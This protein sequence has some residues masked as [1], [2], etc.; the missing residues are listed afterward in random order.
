MADYVDPDIAPEHDAAL[1]RTELGQGEQNISWSQEH[2]VVNLGG[3]TTHF[4]VGCRAGSQ[5]YYLTWLQR[6]MI[7]AE[8]LA[9][10]RVELS[11][12]CRANLGICRLP[13]L[14]K[15]VFWPLCSWSLRSS[16]GPTPWK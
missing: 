15:L 13:P 16:L 1:S 3:S 4:N 7:L 11:V 10:Q 12:M 8:I 9:L 6:K 5:G 14:G 2:A